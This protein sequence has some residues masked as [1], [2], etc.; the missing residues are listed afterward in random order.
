M[1]IKLHLLIY[2]RS[3][4]STLTFGTI[5]IIRKN[6]DKK[7]FQTYN[8]EKIKGGKKYVISNN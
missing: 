6:I 5:S 3:Q 7:E 2:T 4:Q 8:K 1:Y